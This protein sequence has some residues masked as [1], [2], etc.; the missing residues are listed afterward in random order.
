[1]HTPQVETAIN[2][3]CTSVRKLIQL[4][5]SEDR[6]RGLSG[7][8]KLAQSLQRVLPYQQVPFAVHFGG[9]NNG[10]S[11]ANSISMRNPHVDAPVLQ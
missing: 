11:D 4:A 9:A 6:T 8:A 2:A 5:S 10:G 3:T 1:M 7:L